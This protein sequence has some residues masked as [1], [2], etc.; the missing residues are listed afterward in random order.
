MR[1]D[2]IIT[3]KGI[4]D[5]GNGQDSVE[6]ITSG[7]FTQKGEKY[8]ISYE[9]ADDSYYKGYLTTVKLE[10]DRRVTIT[11]KGEYKSQLVLEKG[12]RQLGYYNTEYG[13][14]IMGTNVSEIKSN[15][16]ERGGFIHVDYTLEVNHVLA[17]ENSFYITV[18]EAGNNDDKS[19]TVS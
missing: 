6:F 5:A 18:R 3:I 8:Y 9:E 10:G 12:T 4:Q 7:R 1:K 17:S 11:R 19:Y 2:V 14:L 16:N 13:E 15:M